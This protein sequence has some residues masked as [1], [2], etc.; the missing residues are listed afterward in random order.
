MHDAGKV[1]NLLVGGWEITGVQRYQSGQPVSICC[2]TGIPGVEGDIRPTWNGQPF[3]TTAYTS[4]KFNPFDPN[5]S[6]ELKGLGQ[7]LTDQNAG[8]PSVLAFGN[9]SRVTGAFRTQGYASEDFSLI[10]KFL[11]TE[12]TFFELKVD[13]IN[14]FNR[15]VFNRPDTGLY[16]P[17][18]GQVFGTINAPRNLQLEAKFVF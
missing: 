3:A 18:Y 13:A 7:V 5:N 4:G 17:T 11:V 2:A 9:L 14:A 15:H 10:K 6:V 8:N 16:S 1:T 12:S